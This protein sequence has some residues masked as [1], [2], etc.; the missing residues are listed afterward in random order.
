MMIVFS[1]GS[2]LRG[3][4]GNGWRSHCTHHVDRPPAASHFTAR[5]RRRRSHVPAPPAPPDASVK[6]AP[7]PLDAPRALLARPARRGASTAPSRFA[8]DGTEQ[9][10]R[11]SSLEQSLTRPVSP[12]PPETEPRTMSD[13]WG[14]I[15]KGATDAAETTR[16][17]A[18][19]TKL[20]AEVLYLEQQIKGVLQKF[21]VDVFQHMESNNSAQV[22]Q[23]FTEAKREVDAFRE[24]VAAKNAEIADI[25]RQMENVG[26]GP[27]SSGV[28]M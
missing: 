10:P 28:A 2:G 22:Q 7:I 8:I 5:Q 1:R 26:K 25:N 6:G 9:T 12:P 14:S 21:G 4:C 3:E 15:T 20:Q 18:Q 17:A 16:L 27:Q 24:Q 13:W 23:H 19:R 11:G